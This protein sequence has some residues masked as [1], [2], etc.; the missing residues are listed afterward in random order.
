MGF[1]VTIIGATLGVVIGGGAFGFFAGGFIGFLIFELTTIKSR[2]AE[3][4]R[5]LE[6]SPEVPV[7]EAKPPTTESVQRPAVSE[8]AAAR[9]TAAEPSIRVTPTP[10]APTRKPS[11]PVAKPVHEPTS[12]LF[13]IAFHYVR[14]FFTGGNTLVR[15]GVVVLFFGVAFLLKYAAEHVRVPIELRLVGVTVGAIALLIVGARLRIKREA[16]GLTLEGAAIGILYLVVFAA[17]RLYGLLPA[18][19]AF[20]LLIAIC[21]LSAVLALLQNSL[22]LAVLGAAGGFLAPVLA[23]TGQGSHVMLFGYYAVLNVGILAI[24]WFKAWRLLN[25]VG[26]WF[27][28]VIGATW[29]YRFYRPEFFATTEPFLIFFFLLYVLLAVLYA[30][31]QSPQLKHPVDGTLV[32]GVPIVGF[33]LQVGLVKDYEFG[34]AWS[35][36]AL[37]G[38]YLGSAWLILRNGGAKLLAEVFLALGVIFS[39]LTI[40]LAVDGHWTAAAWAIEGAGI[41]WI[42]LRQSRLL[43][44]LFGLLIQAGAGVFF[45]SESTQS[46]QLAFANSRYVGDLL[47]A[48]SGVISARLLF[49][50]RDRVKQIEREVGTVML[51]WGL[52]WWYGGAFSEI[53]HYVLPE[54][55]VT[56]W[57]LVVSLSAIVQ[58][59]FGARLQWTELRYASAANL[60]FLV[61]AFAWTTAWLA[62]PFSDG[63]FIVWPLALWVCY[64]V[65]RRHE[66]AGLNALNL[67]RHL[68]AFWLLIAIAGFEVHWALAQWLPRSDWAIGGLGLY[69]A[70]VLLTLTANKYLR[71]PLRGN[72]KTYL[73]IAAAPLAVVALVWMLPGAVF[74]PGNPAPLDYIPL[75]N[76]ID[77]AAMF[78]LTALLS[79]TI[80]IRAIADWPPQSP[81]IVIGIVAFVWINAMLF[82]TL[83]HFAQIPYTLRTMLDSVLVQSSLSIFWTLLAFVL[84]VLA[85]RLRERYLWLIGA[86]LLGVVVVKLFVIDL[87]STGTIAR[88]VSFVGV[89]ILLLVIGYFVPVP[90]KSA[91]DG[92]AQP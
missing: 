26:F 3:I 91:T 2:V 60:A 25:L 13:D 31:R 76:P 36:F 15:V 4:E 54:Y 43:A 64:A 82:R 32:F 50:Y 16:Y 11:V 71:W 77:L 49:R 24:A 67:V 40:P 63:G 20:V 61:V 66:S 8:A 86:G 87:S 46:A 83:H 53:Q 1:L 69:V 72:E 5:R 80:R 6:P 22:A 85:I 81:F 19:F 45:L 65:L 74:A 55:R 70:A 59:L 78:V 23:S 75:L 56:A 10:S 88:I 18:L 28:F 38:F 52:V 9:T 30:A 48:L 57:L 47:I 58:E 41:L 51:V 12:D 42:G 44:C 29:G 79:W 92:E 35:A 17:F 7:R 89:G 21:G 33:L 14:E 34:V 37:G 39:T 90:P 73:V 68:G 27:T 62:H 84:M